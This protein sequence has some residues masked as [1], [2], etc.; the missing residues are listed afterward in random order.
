MLKMLAD[1]NTNGEQSLLEREILEVFLNGLNTKL[2]E[3][4]S[5]MGTL[6]LETLA[7]QLDHSE[8]IFRNLASLKLVI[9]PL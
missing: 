8:L 2:R 4:A 1:L 5:S 3:K 7:K 6:E 9:I